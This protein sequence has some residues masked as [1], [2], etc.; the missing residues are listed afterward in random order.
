MLHFSSGSETAGAPCDD[1][2]ALQ[3]QMLTKRSSVLGIPGFGG[4]EMAE[5]RVSLIARYAP[6]RDAGLRGKSYRASGEITGF[7]GKQC[8]ACGE[9]IPGFGGN[10]TGLRGKFLLHMSCKTA[11]F[12]NAALPTV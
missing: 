9:E 6:V 8:R 1:Y 7:G 3:V 5:F 10:L 4:R 2:P 12:S 11:L